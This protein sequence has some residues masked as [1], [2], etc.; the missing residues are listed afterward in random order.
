MH[1]TLPQFDQV[2]TDAG[3]SGKVAHNLASMRHV[4]HCPAVLHH[5]ARVLHC[6]GGGV[7]LGAQFEH[8]MQG[9]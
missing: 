8:G 9:Q 6:F 2:G 1:T 3:Q 7:D 5:C 4:G